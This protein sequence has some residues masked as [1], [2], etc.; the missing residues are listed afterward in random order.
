MCC[1]IFDKTGNGSVDDR[2]DNRLI[3]L[4]FRLSEVAKEIKMCTRPP[5]Y[6]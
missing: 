1:F 2:E 6:F 5:P 3:T 4:A